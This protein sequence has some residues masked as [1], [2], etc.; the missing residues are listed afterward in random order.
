MKIFRE[1]EDGTTL[2]GVKILLR[3]STYKSSTLRYQLQLLAIT[4]YQCKLL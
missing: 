3:L 2:R 1:E 4:M